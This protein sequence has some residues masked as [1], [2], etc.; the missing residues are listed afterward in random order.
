MRWMQVDNFERF[1]ASVFHHWVDRVPVAP[2]VFLFCGRYTGI[3]QQEL[4]FDRRKGAEAFERT[5]AD[6]P[7][8]IHVGFFPRF[9]EVWQYF[10]PSRKRIPGRDGYDPDGDWQ[11]LEEELVGPEVYG[12]ILDRGPN[13]VLADITRDSFPEL[14][15]ITRLI[16]TF[17]RMGWVMLSGIRYMRSWEKR[18]VP[19]IAGASFGGTAFD[20]FAHIRTVPGF[21]K[22]LHQRPR[23]VQAACW[24]V[25][26]YYGSFM[27]AGAWVPMFKIRTG[28]VGSSF[29]S[30]SYVSPTIFESYVLPFMVELASTLRERGII[31]LFHLDSDWTVDLP[32]LRELPRGCVLELDG[33]T[34]IFKAKEILGD[35]LCIM[36][37]VPPALLSLGTPD[38]VDAYCGRLIHEV[39]EGSGFILGAG[40]TV[41]PDA[42]PENVKAMI[43]SAR[44]YKPGGGFLEG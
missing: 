22:D 7:W 8:D 40:C 41:P 20:V 26:K 29:P 1:Q 3:T 23:E 37:D 12:E 14:K 32:Y 42:R 19:C 35:K 30:G 17:L 43:K 4:L 21:L 11:V 34:D 39:G 44:K 31:P 6:M 24:E 10:Y 28:F 9:G 5:Y 15:R 38:E 13:L 18:G 33:S 36:G 16:R 2:N 25:H 27:T